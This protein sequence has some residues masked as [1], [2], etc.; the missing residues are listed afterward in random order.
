[1]A[2]VVVAVVVVMLVTV[3]AV[4]MVAGVV[5]VVVLQVLFKGLER[6][7][8]ALLDGAAYHAEIDTGGLV[9]LGGFVATIPV[10]EVIV[11]ALDVCAA[12]N[13]GLVKLD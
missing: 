10:A 4:V 12:V 5:A 9:A 3:V 7:G 6:V 13:E 11:L 2:V 8:D 1:M